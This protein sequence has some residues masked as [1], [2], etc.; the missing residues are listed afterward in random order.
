MQ[1]SPW[2]EKW[3]NFAYFIVLWCPL[4]FL[5]GLPLAPPLS[6][7]WRRR[8]YL[9]VV[10]GKVEAAW[11]PLTKAVSRYLGKV[12]PRGS[13]TAV[14]EGCISL[15]PSTPPLNIAYY[16]AKSLAIAQSYKWYN[17]MW[18]P[19]RLSTTKQRLNAR[20]QFDRELRHVDVFRFIVRWGG[21]WDKFAPIPKV[22][23]NFRKHFVYRMYTPAAS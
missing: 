13:M 23:C 2:N 14:D 12:E 3:R 1:N 10:L 16:R 19:A 22:Y 21:C 7:S 5:P 15:P 9:G 11:Q 17:F 18:L 4:T 20:Q 6:K 8:C